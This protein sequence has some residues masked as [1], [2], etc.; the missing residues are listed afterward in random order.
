VVDPAGCHSVAALPS[1]GGDDGG[2]TACPY[3]ETF[4][5]TESDDD[6]CKY[7]VIATPI[8]PVCEGTG[9][10]TFK[11][12]LTNK[13]DGSKV[14]GAMTEAEVFTTCPADASCETTCTHG[15]PNNGVILQENPPGTYTGPIQFDLPGQWTVRFHLHWEC[16][17]SPTSPHGHAAYHVIVP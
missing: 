4:D 2:A 10:V 6:D 17:D 8:T 5:G 15:G 1:D 12:V 3:G 13:K 14:T 16:D 7:H 11:V 9:G